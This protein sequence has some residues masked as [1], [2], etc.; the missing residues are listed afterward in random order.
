MT[1]TIADDDVLGPPARELALRRSGTVEVVLL[2]HPE[3][4]RVGLSVFDLATGE[5]FRLDVAPADAIDAFHHPYAYAARR[6]SSNGLVEFAT[7]AAVG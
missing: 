5:G 2:W 1:P 6:A 4:R 3:R 7:V